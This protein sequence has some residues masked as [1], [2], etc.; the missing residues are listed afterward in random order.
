VRVDERVAA[1]FAD[2]ATS[3][4]ITD[5]IVEVEAAAVAEEDDAAATDASRTSEDATFRRDRLNKA[6][7]RLRERLR[8]VRAQEEQARRQAAYDAALVERNALAE[9]GRRHADH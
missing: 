4:S 9:F 5:L 8:E 3:S 6:K 1:A 7:R 2:G